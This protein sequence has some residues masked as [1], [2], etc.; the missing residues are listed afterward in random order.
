MHTVSR[1]F[2]FCYGHRLLEHPGRCAH[3]HGHNAT[4]RITLTAESLDRFGMVVDF[5]ELKRTL[6][7]WIDTELDHKM[8]L[9][10]NDPLLKTLREAGEPIVVVPFNPTAEN[11]ARLIYEK[12]ATFG[13]AVAS[14]TL[15]ETQNCSA[16]YAP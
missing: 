13:F 6:G 14:V 4:I 5:G 9:S 2:H 10:E 16:T 15:W 1:D 12:A 8:L 7:A 11:I 3:L